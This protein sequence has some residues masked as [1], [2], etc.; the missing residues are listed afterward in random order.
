M[1]ISFFYYS[2]KF[3][4]VSTESKILFAIIIAAATTT[5]IIINYN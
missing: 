1:K 5:A 3:I 2:V 4:K